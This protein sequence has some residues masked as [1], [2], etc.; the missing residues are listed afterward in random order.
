[1]N[2]S[3]IA[4][5]ALA[6]ITLCGIAFN[7]VALPAVAPPGSLYARL[8]GTEKV[9]A[10]VKETIDTV[11]AD[12][13][14]NQSF[15]KVDLKR[16]KELLAEQI[17]SLTGGG[18]TYSGDTMKDVHAGHHISNAEFYQLVEVLREAAFDLFVLSAE[19]VH[20]ETVL[21]P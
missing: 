8:G 11:A 18:C 15:D 6:T 16:V 17:C 10:I 4:L 3:R 20:D 9:T 14:M 19:E 21:G 1:M 5:T 7:A 2:R 13:R 12:K